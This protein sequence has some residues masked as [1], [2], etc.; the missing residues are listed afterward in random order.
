MDDDLA[1]A[2]ARSKETKE[3]RERREEREFQRA[4]ELSR[5]SD[6][7]EPNISGTIEIL[8]SDDEDMDP[9]S[10]LAIQQIMIEEDRK[11]AIQI[12]K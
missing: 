5:Q 11:L 9:D 1:T 4:L 10:K 12:Q 3:E 6:T 2:I 8:S 7:A